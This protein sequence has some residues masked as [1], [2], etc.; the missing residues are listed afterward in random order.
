[1]ELE[2]LQ[3]HA[4]LANHKKYKET[5]GA[6]GAIA[7]LRGANLEEAYLEEE[8][9]EEGNLGGANLRWANLRWA[10][11]R[12]ADLQGANLR[13]ADLQG[14][15][16]REANLGGANLREADLEEG[17]LGGANLRG[18]NLREAYLEEGNLGGANLRGANLCGADLRGA[19]LRGANLR[20]ANLRGADLGEADLCIDQCL[21]EVPDLSKLPQHLMQFTK[22]SHYDQSEWCGTNHCIAGEAAIFVGSED[23][24]I[25]ILAIK[26]AMPGFDLDV[27][28]QRDSCAAKEEL[29]KFVG[30]R[31][32][33]AAN[34]RL[35]Q[36][37][38]RSYNR[39]PCK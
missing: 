18:A 24:G 2:Q 21:D 7:D 26:K 4:I 28:Y 19:N 14:A 1:M 12:W 25:G 20:G 38:D 3:L 8:N 33:S 23:P 39:T 30:E 29:A 11:L 34:P 15:N 22:G 5:N 10:N 13:W 36:L 9:L 31:E 37:R 6:E 17:N 27:L 35:L 32:I 16:L